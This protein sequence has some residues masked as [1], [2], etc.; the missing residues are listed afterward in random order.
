M[1]LGFL[2]MTKD[3]MTYYIV[4]AVIIS[5][6]K[7]TCIIFLTALLLSLAGCNA[8]SRRESSS[9]NNSSASLP[10]SS[11]VQSSSAIIQS[12][13][14]VKSALFGDI[15]DY[16][17]GNPKN[18]TD[19]RF[20]FSVDYPAEW[21]AV[22]DKVRLPTS[23]SDG[24]PD[25]GVNIYVEGNK[26][27]WIF[28]DGQISTITGYLGYP[29][30]DFTTKSMIKAKLSYEKIDDKYEINLV[31]DDEYIKVGI[32]VS[33]ACFT[34]NKAQILGILKSIKLV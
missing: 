15:S 13:S 26:N 18:Y 33:E 17:I 29:Y 19:K 10:S 22:A 16:T 32:R 5:M 11:N 3:E 30:E 6:K 2:N 31:F 28:V 8:D 9:F 25:S 14:E 20:D 34:R 7:L 24:D 4:K 12:S 21:T 27:E 1:A 23:S